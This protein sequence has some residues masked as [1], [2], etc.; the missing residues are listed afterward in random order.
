MTKKGR[1]EFDL[2]PCETKEKDVPTQE[3]KSR[4]KIKEEVQIEES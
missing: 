3:E 1:R 2:I 4:L